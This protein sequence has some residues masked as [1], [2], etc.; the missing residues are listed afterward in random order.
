M[1]FSCNLPLFVLSTSFSRFTRSLALHLN[2]LSSNEYILPDSFVNKGPNDANIKT[3]KAENGLIAA[4]K[5]PAIPIF[6][7][8]IENSPRDT[9]VKP[10]FVEALCDNPA[11]RPATI[12]AVKL[13][14]RVM[15]TA[16][17]ANHT[18]PPSENGSILKPKLKRI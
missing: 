4:I 5:P 14:I 12:P 9:S 10:I 13:P 11:L 18:A 1:K 16:P 17:N 15:K 3:Y 8:I 6:A 7:T 2:T